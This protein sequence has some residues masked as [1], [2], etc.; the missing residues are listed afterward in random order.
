MARYDRRCKR[1]LARARLYGE[2]E[3]S[4]GQIGA[5]SLAVMLR[6]PP[7]QHG[8]EKANRRTD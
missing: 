5:E 1:E 7:L 2:Q 4:E 3:E 6:T 8:R